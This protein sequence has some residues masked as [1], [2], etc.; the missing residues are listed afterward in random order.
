MR[1]YLAAATFTCL[2][3]FD[4]GYAAQAAKP[5]SETIG[6]QTA[7]TPVATTSDT[8]VFVQRSDIADHPNCVFQDG[9]GDLFIAQEYVKKLEFDSYGLAVVF[10]E[11]HSGHLFMYVNRQGRVVIK[12]VPVADN[13]AEGFSDGVVRIFVNKKY[14]FADRQGKI[15][16]APQY[17]GAGPFEHGFAVVCLGCRETCAVSNPPESRL[18]VCEHHIMTGGEWFKIN[19][20]G[21]VVARVPTDKDGSPLLQ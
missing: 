10:H 14:G 21:R 7:A 5:Q 1:A 19:K 18:D 17:D 8:C 20:A 15:V 6:S 11:A 9:R 2:V 4:A 3:F 16:I 13:W 12:D